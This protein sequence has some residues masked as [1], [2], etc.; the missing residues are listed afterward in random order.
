MPAAV[1]DLHDNRR[2]VFMNGIC[3][4]FKNIDF[5]VMID[6]GHGV[7][8]LAVR[9]SSGVSGYDCADIPFCQIDVKFF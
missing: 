1:G 9:L 7:A 3:N 2:A 6:H 8:D 5:V 4:F